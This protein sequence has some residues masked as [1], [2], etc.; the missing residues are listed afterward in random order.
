MRNLLSIALLAVA[1]PVAAPLAAQNAA[2]PF[3]VQE[4][5]RGFAKLDEALM[6]IRGQDATILIAPGTY[7]ECAIQQAGHIV[8]RAARPGSVIF[9]QTAC[10]GKA[11]LVLRGAGST[12]DGVVFR[13]FHVD[14]GNGAGI[15]IESGDL[16]VRNAMFLDSQEGILGGSGADMPITIDHT[17]F[18]EL[19]QCDQSPRCAHSIYLETQGLVTVTHSRFERGNGGHYIK[20]RGPRV[21]IADNSFDD[22]GGHKTNYM[23]DLP[24]GATGL[25]RGNTFVQGRDKENWTG[26]IVVA[27]E[28]HDHS[29]AGLR[30]E[31]NTASLAPGET[32]SPAFVADYSHERLAIG[33]N[34][35][36]K[37]VRAFETR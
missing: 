2:L 29:A 15:R 18:A 8:F 11:A 31:G 3:T 17:T 34:R 23:I 35:L 33:D 9:E 24:N 6:A 1:A 12:V 26:F 5:G 19:G 16:T 27:A 4:S 36:G 28:A 20:V 30:I 37:G 10:E 13:G 21:T 14:D 25:I 7:H 32:R 22:T